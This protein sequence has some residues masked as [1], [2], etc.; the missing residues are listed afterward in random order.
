MRKF[1]ATL[2]LTCAL[3]VG[4]TAPVA[5][6]QPIIT[7]GLVNITVVDLL[8]NNN[9]TLDRVVTVGAA[10][11]VAANVCDVSVGVLARQLH[12]GDTTCE[13]ADQTARAI[14]SQP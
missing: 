4:A 1:F 13:N 3:A 7:G 14:I 6:A 11:N 12:A 9:V 2:F 10:L 5:S 8:N